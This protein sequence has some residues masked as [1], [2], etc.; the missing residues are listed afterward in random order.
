MRLLFVFLAFCLCQLGSA[1]TATASPRLAGSALARSA[2][3]MKTGDSVVQALR[4]ESDEELATQAD[5]AKAALYDMRHKRAT[6]QTVKNSEYLSTKYKISVINT[7][8]SERA[9]K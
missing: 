1:F 7:I 8:M 9:A 5:A 2:A 6:R 4:K 3:V